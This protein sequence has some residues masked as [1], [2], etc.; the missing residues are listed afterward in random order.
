MSRSPKIA[1]K[2][3][4]RAPGAGRPAGEPTRQVKIYDADFAWLAARGHRSIAE[5]VRALRPIS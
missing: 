4:R 2:P 5:A 3:R 1:T